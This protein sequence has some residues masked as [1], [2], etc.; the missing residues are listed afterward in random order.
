MKTNIKIKKLSFLVAFLCV[1][2][3]VLPT[4]TSVETENKNSVNETISF[5]QN[6]S[7]PTYQKIGEYI[8]VDV[9]EAN[10]RL[11]LQG[12]PDLPVFRKTYE[13]PWDSEILTINFSTS[14]IETID[15]NNS[16]IK[17]TP[18]FKPISYEKVKNNKEPVIPSETINNDI[19]PDTWYDIEKG[20]GLSQDGEHVKFLTFSIYPTRHKSKEKILEYITKTEVE[21]QYESSGEEFP[22]PDI[23]DLLIIAPSYFEENLTKLVEHKEKYNVKTNLTTLEEIYCNFKGR[24]KPEKIKYFIKNA[25]EE[26]GIKYVLLV[27]EI[28]KTPIR[29][30]DSCFFEGHHGE[31]VLSDLYYADIYDYN[32]NF[33]TWDTNND[34]IFGQ[35]EFGRSWNNISFEIIDEVDLYPDLHVGRLAC[36]NIDEVD[37]VVDKIINYESKTYGEDWFNKIILAGGDT[38]PPGR[39]SAPFVYEGEINNKKVAEEME[40]FEHIKL[41]ATKRNLNAFTFNRA[42]NNG[43]GFLSYAGHGFEHGWGTYRP[44]YMRNKLGLTNPIYHT[45]MIQFLKNEYKLPIIFFDACLTAKLDFNLKDLADYYTMLGRLIKLTGLEINQNNHLP[46]FAW[47]FLIEEDGG[48]IGTIGATRTAY[49]FVDKDGVHIGAGYLDWMF[50]QGYHEGVRLGEMLT[51]AQNSYINN[52]FKDYFTIEEYILLGDPSLMVGGYPPQ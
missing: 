10:S 27:G 6:F 23:Y 8:K 35:I 13:I 5:T 46:C 44:N 15:L 42:I 25:V 11:Y 20:S 3:L 19:Y 49:S 40:D 45:P 31:G 29:Q 9:E 39:G 4:I 26:W 30:T 14:D 16:K 24:D 43:A 48:A 21:V 1:I 18:L 51:Y 41:W 33:S 38:F 32:Y 37:I 28:R 50:F 47:C 22:D 12:T 7:K 17:N 34:S 52:R 36:R 2:L